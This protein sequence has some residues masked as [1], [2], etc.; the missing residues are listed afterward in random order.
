[1][2]CQNQAQVHEYGVYYSETCTLS[3]LFLFCIKYFQGFKH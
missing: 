1:M 2:Y 3:L